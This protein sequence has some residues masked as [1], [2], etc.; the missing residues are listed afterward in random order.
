MKRIN[1]ESDFVLQVR[2]PEEVIGNDFRIELTTNGTNIYV[3]SRINGDFSANIVEGVNPNEY[4]IILRRHGLGCGRL[5]MKVYAYYKN[6][7]SPDGKIQEVVPLTNLDVELW[8]KATDDAEIPTIEIKSG[9]WGVYD[10][11]ELRKLT[12]DTRDEAFKRI[13]VLNEY[14]DGIKNSLD[15]VSATVD[16]LTNQIN[17][18]QDKLVSKTNIKT[19][20]G[21]SVLGSGNIEIKEYDE[22]KVNALVNDLLAPIYTALTNAGTILEE[23]TAQIN[24]RATEES[25]AIRCLALNQRIINIAQTVDNNKTELN[26]RILE[27]SDNTGIMFNALSAELGYRPTKAEVDTTIKNAITNTLNTVV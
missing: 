4:S 26:D 13:N 25:V 7:N 5:R 2:L 17:T 27:L 14:A 16:L 1:Y 19:I 15:V 8:A 22:D 23:H 9:G 18:K 11:T 21:Q 3:A 10:D 24:L 20:N 6:V 12:L